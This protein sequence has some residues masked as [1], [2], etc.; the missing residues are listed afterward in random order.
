MNNEECA[1][2]LGWCTEHLQ[3]DLSD[4]DESSHLYFN[5]ERIG[6]YAGDRR[7]YFVDSN[8]TVARVFR[9]YNEWKHFDDKEW[10]R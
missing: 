6:G 2:F 4:C 3:C 1:E 7:E 10:A 9:M 8:D 5:G